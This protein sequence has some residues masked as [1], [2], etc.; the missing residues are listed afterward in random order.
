MCIQCL[1]K[2]AFDSHYEVALARDLKIF[3]V[4][5]CC[6]VFGLLEDSDEL[7]DKS[8]HP[9]PASQLLVSQS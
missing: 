5:G 1:L 3:R 4:Y 7:C 2:I 8:F 9:D 6:L